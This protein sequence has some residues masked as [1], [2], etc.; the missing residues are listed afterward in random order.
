MCAGLAAERVD[1]R[2]V[3]HATD[4]GVDDVSISDVG[5]LI[6][7]LREMLDVLL[8]GLVSP[9]PTVVKVPRVV[10]LR[11]CTLE[12]ADEDRTKIAQAADAARLELLEP[13]LGQT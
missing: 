3:G 6:V 8:E 11:V 12:V 9:L 13:S 4:E 10:G 5:E 7:L 2:L 1:E